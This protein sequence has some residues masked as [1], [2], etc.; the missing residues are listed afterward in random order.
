MGGNKMGVCDIRTFVLYKAELYTNNSNFKQM[1]IIAVCTQ[2]K[3]L[4]KKQ[5]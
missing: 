2:L 5:A 4:R 3:Q 1:K